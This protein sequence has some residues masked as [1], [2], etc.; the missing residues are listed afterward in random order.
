MF[1]LLTFLNRPS[2]T[3]LVLQNCR[4]ISDYCLRQTL[5]MLL[6]L[7]KLT[8]SVS[9]LHEDTINIIGQS[10]NQLFSFDI[11]IY[12]LTVETGFNNHAIAIGTSMPLLQNLSISSTQKLTNIG[13]ESIIDGCH[14]LQ[15]LNIQNCVILTLTAHMRERCE[16][17]IHNIIWPENY[18]QY[19]EDGFLDDMDDIRHYG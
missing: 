17:E 1:N 10:C 7:Q 12:S 4:A 18:L 16:T 11:T 14:N 5:P 2:I 6:N 19:A 9:H 8:L 13:I 3:L 15:L